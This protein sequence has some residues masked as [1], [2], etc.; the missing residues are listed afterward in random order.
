MS[1]REWARGL[2][3]EARA[4]LIILLFVLT[5]LLTIAVCEWIVSPLPL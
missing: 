5:V 1:I 4:D 2:S 3:P